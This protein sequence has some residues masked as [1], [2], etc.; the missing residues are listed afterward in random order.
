MPTVPYFQA[1]LARIHHEGF[2]FHADRVAP[3][4]LRIL[5]PV[6]DRGGVVLEVGCGTG[7]LTKYL[8]EH[9][10]RVI[11]TDASPAMV[12]LA[13]KYVPD[14]EAIEVVRLPNDAVP[15]AD[16]IVSV[17]HALNYLEDGAQVDRALTDLCRSLRPDG[18]I[19]FDICDLRYGEN[20]RGEQAKVWRTDDWVLITQTSVPDARSFRRDMTMFVRTAANAWR[21]ADE[22]HDNV[23]IET[24]RLPAF[25]ARHSV[26]GEVRASFGNEELPIGLVAVVGA[27]T[28]EPSIP[29]SPC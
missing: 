6:R 29:D 23:L 4:V 21:R 19:A 5:E 14:T 28:R 20:R 16:A 27:K 22:L 11:A 25:L 3:G 12:E 18:I 8:V 2:G 15:P 13:R 10:H 7:L 24:S 9:G 26:H 17:G 1:E